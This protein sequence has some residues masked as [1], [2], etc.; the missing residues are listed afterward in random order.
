M[1]CQRKGANRVV[2]G[3]IERRRPLGRTRSR[4]ENDIKMVLKK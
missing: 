3:K 4:W 1:Y 2:V